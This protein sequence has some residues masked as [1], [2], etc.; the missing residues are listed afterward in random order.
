VSCCERLETATASGDQ[1][2]VDALAFG[3]P[4]EVGLCALQHS[5]SPLPLS[6]AMPL[7]GRHRRSLPRWLGGG[8]FWHPNNRLL[9]PRRKR[10]VVEL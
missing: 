8:R 7:D 6:P 3:F 2:E 10:P 4:A 5:H 9:R 1:S